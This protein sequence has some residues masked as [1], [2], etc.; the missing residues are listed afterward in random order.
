MK[1]FNVVEGKK[2]KYISIKTLMN[3]LQTFQWN[4]K[5]SSSSTLLTLIALLVIVIVS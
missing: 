3:K 5:L 1:R 4:S 2:I